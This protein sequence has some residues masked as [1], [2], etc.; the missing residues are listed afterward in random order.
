MSIQYTLLQCIE[1]CD[2]GA[3]VAKCVPVV[4]VVFFVLLFFLAHSRAKNAIKNIPSAIEIQIF[5]N[6]N[7]NV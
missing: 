6:A 4:Y 5:T 1:M 7:V 3:L 2:I